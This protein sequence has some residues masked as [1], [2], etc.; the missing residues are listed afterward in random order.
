MVVTLLNSLTLHSKKLDR[1]VEEK[2]KKGLFKN[3]VVEQIAESLLDQSI[4]QQESE[5]LRRKR[6]RLVLSMLFLMMLGM[7]FITSLR[8]EN[9][10]I[11]LLFFSLASTGV[12]AVF[13]I[14]YFWLNN[15]LERRFLR[16]FIAVTKVHYPE[17]SE[18]YERKFLQGD[19]TDSIFS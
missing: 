16:E 17:I 5:Q 1:K 15:K 9:Y 7:Q 13:L 12:V 6:L 10:P 4:R 3:E 18:K 8:V 14:S 2:L 11:G 19:K